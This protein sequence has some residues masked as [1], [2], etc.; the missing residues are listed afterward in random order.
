MVVVRR[1]V[2]ANAFAW[3]NCRCLVCGWKV[4][5]WLALSA[6]AVVVPTVATKLA[7]NALKDDYDGSKA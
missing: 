5:G 4:H 7:M 1:W 6:L 3:L 2:V